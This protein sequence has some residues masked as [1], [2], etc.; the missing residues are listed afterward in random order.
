MPPSSSQTTYGTFPTTAAG[1]SGTNRVPCTEASPSR[2]TA[3]TA[4]AG[5][6]AAGI[7][8]RGSS[9]GWIGVSR[10]RQQLDLSSQEQYDHPGGKLVKHLKDLRAVQV[11]VTVLFMVAAGA[12]LWNFRI[13]VKSMRDYYSSELHTSSWAADTDGGSRRTVAT[14]V[15][16]FTLCLVS[17]LALALPSLCLDI[18]L[19]IFTASPNARA[20]S[21]GGNR[22]ACIRF[23]CDLAWD[24]AFAFVWAAVVGL[25]CTCAVV[26]PSTL[27]W[28]A[29]VLS[30]VLF[31]LRVATA[32]LSGLVRRRMLWA[33]SREG[34]GVEWM[35]L[36]A[37]CGRSA[38]HEFNAAAVSASII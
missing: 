23:T 16:I 13:A 25:C 34:K 21:C 10:S 30:L 8:I 22:T 14:G 19:L 26:Y 18:V 27:I 20:R 15:A 9:D 1:F 36:A 7:S 32:V 35:E 2:P 12:V 31:A 3:K 17:A 38:R 24:I 28:V 4:A 5:P 33:A 29:V 37:P 11:V 6:T